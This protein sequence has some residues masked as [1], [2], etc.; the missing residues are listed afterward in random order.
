MAW[1]NIKLNAGVIWHGL[2]LIKLN[3]GVMWVTI[4]K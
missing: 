1:P 3:A 2:I 4:G